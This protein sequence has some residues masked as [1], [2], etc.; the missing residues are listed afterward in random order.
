MRN[1]LSIH[2]HS[3]AYETKGDK[4]DAHGV[5]AQWRTE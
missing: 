5:T 4:Y 3:H 1:A 2:V